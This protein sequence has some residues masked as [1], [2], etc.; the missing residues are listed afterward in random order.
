MTIWPYINTQAY[1]F[2]FVYILKSFKLRE[3]N[4]VLFE[5]RIKSYKLH[6]YSGLYIRVYVYVSVPLLVAMTTAGSLPCQKLITAAIIR[7]SDV[8]S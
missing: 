7:Q 2:V 3:N 1:A 8:K 4:I 5:L 6:I